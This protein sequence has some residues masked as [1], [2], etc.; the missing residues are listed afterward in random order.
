MTY[1]RMN[2]TYLGIDPGSKGAIAVL[3]PALKHIS[4]HDLSGTTPHAI[5]QFF[6]EI[7]TNTSINPLVITIE[8]VHAIPGTSAG[9]NFKFG[10]NVGMINAL[11]EAS[12]IGVR[13]ITPKAWQKQIGVTV[14]GKAIKKQ[15]AEIAEKLYPNAPIRGSRGGLL[16]G[17]SDALMIA[18]TTYLTYDGQQ[19]KEEI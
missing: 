3:T 12:Q 6:E 7:N 11:A 5:L 19:S 8:K 10:Y 16:D 4:F 1:S 15:V 17:R 13:H 9:S 2:Y 14:K 18:H